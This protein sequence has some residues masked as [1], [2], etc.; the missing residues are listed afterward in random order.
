M[1][2]APRTGETTFTTP[3]DREVVAA[4]VFEAPRELVWKAYT[5]PEHI[6][7]W[8]LGYE[9]WTMAVC[10]VD[11]R[12]G[13]AYRYAWRN[14]DGE[15]LTISGVHKEVEPPERLVATESWG[16]GGDWPEALNTIVLDEEDG[17]TTLTVTVRYP[18][19]EARDAALAT[20]MTDGW[21]QSYDWLDEHLGSL[22][23]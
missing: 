2:T 5:E 6:R 14:E 1:T 16:W 7:Q 8:M 15:E 17:R 21:S 18:S 22:A 4:R 12:P 19:Q 9:G 20:G 23:P 13:G 10:E 3:S 11:L